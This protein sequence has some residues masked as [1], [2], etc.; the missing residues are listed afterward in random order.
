MNPIK[1][2]LITSVI[3]GGCTSN[4]Q[5]KI[6]NHKENIMTTDSTNQYG[7][8]RDFL[9][10]HISI[11]ELKN[12]NSAIVLSPSWQ[13]RVMTSTAEGDS[14]FSFGW[15]NREL[16]A[17]GKIQSHINAYGGEERL[18]L[19]PEGG[20]FSIF[21]SKGKSFIYDNWQTPAFLDTTPFQLISST[22]SSALFGKDITTGNYSGTSFKFRIE[23]EVTL[24]SKEALNKLISLD[25]NGL[26]SVAYRSVN[27][28]INQGDIAWKKETGLLSIWMLG[29]FNPSPAI[30]ITIPVKTG[31]EKLIGPKVNDAY[32]GKISNDRL[33]VSG[34]NIFFKA[35]G[36]S[37]GKIGIPPLRAT[38]VMGSYDS[39]NKILTLLICRM[40]EGKKDYV[41][42]SWQIQE[43]PFSGD[44]LNSY[45]DGPLADGSQMGPFY[46]LETSSPAADLKPGESLSHIQYTLHLKG[47]VQYLDKVAQKVLGVSLEE[48]TG[49]F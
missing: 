35:D 41:N 2:L 45:N 15:I 39:D 1:F 31:D 18:W 44:A 12:G 3:L 32:F 23:R 5:A 11:I 17:S 42:S 14:G 16:I 37:R 33:K 22:D 40:A 27:K 7:F 13:G 19:G 25:V 4:N 49:A 29:M 6:K 48:I 8:N 21:F 30:I 34:N 26:R 43:N 9:K 20:Q 28:I 47:D 38:G 24:L 46:E 10:K 36:K